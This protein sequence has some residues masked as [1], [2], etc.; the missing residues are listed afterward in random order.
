MKKNLLTI[1][2][3]ITI[4]SS[5][6]IAQ[7]TLTSSNSNPVI[8]DIITLQSY[9]YT[10]PGSAGANQ[11]W[12][13]SSITQTTASAVSSTCTAVSPSNAATFPGSNIQ[14]VATATSIGFGN[15]NS[16]AYQNTRV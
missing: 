12:N 1:L 11:T 16:S 13:F 4:F 15:A 6:A 7:P 10:S 2:T 9:S 5:V 14:S 8:G 3:A